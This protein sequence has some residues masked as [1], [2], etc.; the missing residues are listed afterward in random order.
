[1]KSFLQLLKAAVSEHDSRRKYLNVPLAFD[2]EVSSFVGSNGDEV[3]LVYLWGLGIMLNGKQY[4]TVGRHIEEFCDLVPQMN[5]VLNHV[6]ADVIIY[7]HHLQY[8]IS[9]IYKLL[10]FDKMFMVKPRKVLYAK[11]GHVIFRDSL[12]LAGGRSLDRLSQN[13]N[14]YKVRKL[15][16]SLDYDLI[17]SPDTPL[18]ARERAYQ[19]NDVRV[20][21]S[22]VQEKIEQDGSIAKIPLTN[23]G[24]VRQA[25][26]D[27]YFGHYDRN[28][29][30]VD[31][32]VLPPRAYWVLKRCQAGGFTHAAEH[33]VGADLTDVGSY[34]I[35]SSYP[36]VMLT[37]YFP[38]SAPQMVKRDWITPDRFEELCKKYC[39]T[40][41]IK[42]TNVTTKYGYEYTL[43]ESKMIISEDMV[44]KANLERKSMCASYF[45]GRLI[46]AKWI[47][48][49][50]TELDWDTF[51]KFYNYDDMEVEECWFYER[52]KLPKQVIVPMMKWFQNKT[53][54]DGI[55][56][57][58]IE[59]MISKNM[60]NAIA[61]CMEMDP[62]RDIYEY[63]YENREF[64]DTQKADLV[65][66]VEQVNDD[67]HRFL[68]FPWGVW[69]LAQA[70]HKLLDV[71]AHTGSDHVYSDTDSEKLTN[72]QKYESYFRTLNLELE[73]KTLEA[74]KYYGLSREDVFPRKPNGEEA[75]LGVFEFE[76]V[77]RRFKT[78]GAK[79]Y[80]V[81]YY[82]R[83]NKGY[84]TFMLTVAGLN[85]RL[86]LEYL[87]DC[88]F[89]FINDD[90]KRVLKQSRRCRRDYDESDLTVVGS[91][92]VNR[93]PFEMFNMGLKVPPEHSGRLIMKYIDEPRKGTATD[94]LGNQ[95][96][97][98]AASGIYSKK[99]GYEI[100]AQTRERE[101]IDRAI[102]I[103]RQES[104]EAAPF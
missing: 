64:L 44:G 39:V 49:G 33:H 10:P 67:P 80:L 59:Y 92:T 2:T 22:Y 3:G 85:K 4:V 45:N 23:T 11:C 55:S 66:S 74:A 14:R 18:T 50:F 78:L 60:L 52:G 83:K 89:D 29:N 71:V 34:D 77:Y 16:G 54:M 75:R 90:F 98:Y 84:T 21:L 76:G 82:P 91:H 96:S 17:R 100:N 68:Y 31:R 26:R 99:G 63:D 69:I 86:G 46:C 65:E 40:A 87:G 48:Y 62:V 9:F 61:G 79:R 28:A 58:Q 72:Y 13:L 20:L 93:D 32:L 12:L 5:E 41:I 101:G 1:M 53:T 38:M 104:E 8:D 35:K 6:G 88:E 37:E 47:R 97:Y 30:L 73:S 25:L 36:G 95:F 43:S 103:L 24:Y 81:E 19:V 57:K 102:M 70:R 51:K 15:V 94:Y 42:L 27:S 7:V 56:E